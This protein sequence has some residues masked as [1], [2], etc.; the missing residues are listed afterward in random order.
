RRQSVICATVLADIICFELFVKIKRVLTTSTLFYFFADYEK[1]KMETQ[2]HRGHRE[3][4]ERKIFTPSARRN[5][6]P[7][8]S[9]MC[10][11]SPV[12]GSRLHLEP[13]MLK[14]NF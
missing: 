7:C 14:I 11:A 1:E 8:S 9:S 13:Q 3:H 6:S 5:V 2:S 10:S 4:R 12:V